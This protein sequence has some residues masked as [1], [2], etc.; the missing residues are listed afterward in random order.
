MLIRTNAASYR[1]EMVKALTELL[2]HEPRYCKAPTFAYEFNIGTL[3][4]ETT[5]HLLPSSLQITSRLGASF[6]RLRRMPLAL[7]SSRPLRRTKQ[8]TILF[9]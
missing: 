6:A 4:R 2:G 7:K 1:K 8:I 9:T 5:L 3:D